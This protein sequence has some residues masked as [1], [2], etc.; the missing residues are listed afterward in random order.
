MKIYKKCTIRTEQY[1]NNCL[2]NRTGNNAPY[3]AKLSIRTKIFDTAV[4]AN[5]EIYGDEYLL[6]LFENNLINIIAIDVVIDE[7]GYIQCV[8]DTPI[9]REEGE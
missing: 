9:V 5:A 8:S 2:I 1:D 4:E 7:D 6:R 3:W